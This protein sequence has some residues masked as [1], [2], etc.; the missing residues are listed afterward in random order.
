MPIPKPRKGETEKKFIARCMGDD[1]MQEFEPPQRRAV[2]QSQWERKEKDSMAETKE[3]PGV[4]LKDAIPDDSEGLAELLADDKRR[5]QVMADPETTADF[6]QKYVRSV[7]KARPDIQRLIDDGVQKGMTNFMLENGVNRPDITANIQELPAKGAAYNKHAIGAAL[8]KEFEDWPDF[9]MS[10]WH[11]NQAGMDRWRKIRND[12]SSLEPSA[13]GFL[14][15]E[16]LRAE[17]LRV[18]LETAVVRP[19]ARVIP[20]DSAR[21]PFPMIDSTSHASSVF[22]GVTAAWTEEGGT[23]GESEAKF[24]RVV[25]DAKKLAART[26]VPNELLQ[27]SIISF[28]AF[29]EDILPQAISWFEDT[30]FLTG[31]GA[32]EPAGVL[33]A[34]ALVAITKE[35]GQPA[36][37]IVWENLVKMYARMLPSSLGRAVWVANNDTFPELA[38]M[39]L[40]VGT[41]G[42]AIWLNNG[43][44]G[45]PATIL[46]R[47]LILTEKVPTIGDA[48]DILFIDFGYYLIGDRQQMRAESS[49]HAQFTTDQTVFRVIE[50]VDGRP[51]LQSAIT[52]QNGTN[53]LSP[54]IGLAARA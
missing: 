21:V 40:S 38:T 46:G 44:A 1:A 53:T 35:A 16:V 18:A 13:G 45:P 9:L 31:V 25:L 29:I 48:N 23:L 50:R 42:G 11:Q 15:P 7:N 52:P 5:E 26:D 8:N 32:G 47:P 19:R 49:A 24:G 36:D 4:I 54:F 2:C 10:V 30:G 27:D 22:G 51:W 37:T 20:M 39:A 41:G 33:N 28:A 3:A 43:V 34:S 6:L 14:V 12:Y 17:L